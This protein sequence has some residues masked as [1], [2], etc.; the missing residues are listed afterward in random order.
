MGRRG[1][2]PSS[3]VSCRLRVGRW[4]CAGSRG[5][6]LAVA[7]R[8]HPTRYDRLRTKLSHK[9]YRSISLTLITPSLSR[10]QHALVHASDEHFQAFPSTVLLLASASFHASSLAA[11]FKCTGISRQS[12]W[13]LTR[14]LPEHIQSKLLCSSYDLHHINC[15]RTFVRTCNREYI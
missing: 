2:S 11:F 8:H 14:I 12:L 1:R 15:M 7:C 9:L 4:L 6:T 3:C 13:D 5:R 10:T